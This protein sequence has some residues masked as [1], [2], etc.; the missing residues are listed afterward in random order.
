MTD[1][2]DNEVRAEL[3][4]DEYAAATDSELVTRLQGRLALA[5][6]ELAA[7]RREPAP[8]GARTFKQICA[9]PCDNIDA[10]DWYY[11]GFNSAGEIYLGQQRPYETPIWCGTIPR[12]TFEAWIDWYNTGKMPRRPRQPRSQRREERRP[13]AD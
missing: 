5:R 13:D 11:L 10:G 4:A 12:R 7:I 9:L 2:T 8:R 1:L 3:R 6:R